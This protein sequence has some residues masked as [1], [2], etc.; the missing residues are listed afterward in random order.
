MSESDE[1]NL[2]YYFNDIDRNES[3]SILQSI[4]RPGCFLIRRH[5]QNSS[6]LSSSLSIESPYVLSIVAPS[7]KIVHFLI[8]RINKY[9]S[10][11]VDS[12]EYYKSLKELVQSHKLNSGIL[13]CKLIEYPIRIIFNND[14]F[15]LPHLLN[16]N[17]TQL[18]RKE[19]IGQGYF[20]IV[21]KGSFILIFK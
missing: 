12:D 18:I 5:K 2:P 4:K 10:I 1:I 19:I 11:K 3:E 20:G 17:E 8:Y 7:L 21:Y 6:I 13:P 14:Q 15:S 9:L 16:I